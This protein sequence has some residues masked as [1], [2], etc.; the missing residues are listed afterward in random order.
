MIIFYVNVRYVVMNGRQIK[1]VLKEAR[2][3]PNALPKIIMI[4]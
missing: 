2:N 4:F 3:V 1:M